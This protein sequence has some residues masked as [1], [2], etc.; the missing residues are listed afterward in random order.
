VDDNRQ[1]VVGV[2]LGGTKILAGIVHG[3]GTVERRRERPTPLGSPQE[4]P[5]ALEAEVDD[6]RDGAVAAVGFGIPTRV[7]YRTGRSAGA[8]NIPLGELDFSGRM[9][10]RFGLPVGV[11]ND[12]NAAT[13]AEWRFGAGRGTRDLV[14]LTL[15][16]GVG[17]GV[18]VDGAL[19]RGWAELG[20]IVV[21]H[22]GPPCPGACT[23]RGHLEAVASGDAAS[24]AAREAFGPDADARS[25]VRLAEEGDERARE[26]LG[27]IGRKLG[28]GI[29]SL[30]N[31]FN[32]EVVVIG[33]GFA[34]AGELILASAREVAARE[35]LAPAGERLR[36]VRAELGEAAGLIGAGLLAIAS[37]EA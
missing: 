13:L 25:L 3:D 5:A 32:P 2:D 16:T 35:A 31:I 17:G 14:M 34:A 19:F 4:R 8:V 24:R 21:E 30:V 1:R 12:A 11:D 18:I 10:N 9:R 7:D 36:I 37:L 28:S 26:I 29:G 33:G 23:G 20:H 27:E 6:L 15:G 22:D